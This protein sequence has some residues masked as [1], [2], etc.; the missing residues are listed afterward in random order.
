LS[1]LSI[2]TS[3][4]VR[5]PVGPVPPPAARLPAEP[6]VIDGSDELAVPVVADGPLAAPPA[7]SPLERAS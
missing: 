3:L 1:S 4:L 6:V 5:G 7:L 2:A